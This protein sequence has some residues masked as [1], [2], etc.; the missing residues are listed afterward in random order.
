MKLLSIFVGKTT[1]VTYQGREI[2]TGIYKTKVD[3]SVQVNQLIWRE[4]INNW[5]I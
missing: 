4:F 3:G 1:K 2:E 5:F